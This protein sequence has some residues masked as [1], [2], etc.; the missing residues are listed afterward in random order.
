VNNGSAAINYGGPLAPEDIS[1]DKTNTVEATGNVGLDTNLY[2]T[3]ANMCTDFPTCSNVPPEYV[4]AIAQQHWDSVDNLWA[5]M[6]TLT[7][8]T[9]DELELN[10]LK[11]TTTGSPAN[12]NVHWKIKIPAGQAS[13]TY[14][15]ENTIAGKKGEAENW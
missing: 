10:C 9:S 8:N 12:A 11:T 3:N 15:G 13:D 4:I 2:S 5:S 6:S 7:T 14:T 1:A